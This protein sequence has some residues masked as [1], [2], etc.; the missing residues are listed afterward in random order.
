M[1]GN[2]QETV[3]QLVYLK[4]DVKKLK[5]EIVS[6]DIAIATMEKLQYDSDTQIAQFTCVIEEL[7]EK[8]Q[9]TEAEHKNK[10]NIVVLEYE[11]KIQR[12]AAEVAQLQENLT[13]QAARTEANIEAYRRKVEDLE[14]K[15]KQSK[16]KEYLAQ[17][18]Y[19]S[20]GQYENRVE[21]PY[22]M[23][24]NYTDSFSTEYSTSIPESPK[25]MPC[26]MASTLNKAV[27]SP[28]L[29]IMYSDTKTPNMPRNDK[30]GH[31]NI[32][33][34]RKLYNEKDFLNQ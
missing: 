18:T 32:T 16:F 25:P 31:F 27:K 34:K 19:P 26:Q 21:R 6:K 20:E 13:M 7:R 28:A 24:K 12:S 30:K 3:S 11:E 29:Q 4:R 23:N 8:L 5:D 2:L 22:S 9:E 17:N 33:K 1:I 14:E 15:L 10:M